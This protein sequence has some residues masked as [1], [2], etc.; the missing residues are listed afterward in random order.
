MKKPLL[1]IVLAFAV[2]S[3]MAQDR[4][5]GSRGERGQ[6]EGQNREWTVQ[7]RAERET[8]RIHQVVNLSD[9]QIENVYKVVY[10]CAKQ[11]PI[12]M[13]TWRAQRE[14]GAAQNFDRE[15]FRK[16]REESNKLKMDALKKIFTKEQAISYDKWLQEMEQQRQQGRPGGQGQRGQRPSN[17]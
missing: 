5:Q 2:L 7:N 9:K 14:S 13:A 17:R 12:Q 11:D 1:S 8:A 15:A 16:Q 10:A 3:T 6:R 4:P